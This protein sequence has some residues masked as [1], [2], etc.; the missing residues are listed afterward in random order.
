VAAQRWRRRRRPLRAGVDPLVRDTDVPALLA[1][2]DPWGWK[3]GGGPLWCADAAER[4][5]NGPD[6][7]DAGHLRRDALDAGLERRHPFLHDAQLLQDVLSL[8]PEHMFDPARDR[9]LLRDALTDAIPD[10]V[11]TRHAKSFFTALSTEALAGS[12]GRAL[13]AQL[14]SPAAPVRAYVRAEALDELAGIATATGATRDVMAG[15]LFGVAAVDH[16][17]RDLGG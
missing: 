10:S 6:A 14:A 11:R 7:M 1:E 12:E 3:R 9:P 13:I 17:L 5:V 8:P 16:W 15:R 2:A 4:L